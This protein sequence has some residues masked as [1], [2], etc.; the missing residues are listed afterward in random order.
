MAYE[1]V[2]NFKKLTFGMFNN[3]GLYSILG[4]GEWAEK[5]L[6]IDKLY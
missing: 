2:E 6:N 1:Y 3:F 5:I 4:K